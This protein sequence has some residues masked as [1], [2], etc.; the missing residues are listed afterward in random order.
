[1]ILITGAAGF[2]GSV[3]AKSLFQEGQKDLLLVDDFSVESKITNWQSMDTL[4]RIERSLLFDYLDKEKP[5]ISCVIHMGARTD[6]TEFNKAIFDE[7]NLN[8]SKALWQ[9]CA[10]SK[11][12]LIYASSAATYGDGKLGYKDD[13]SIIYQLKPLNPYGESKNNFDQ[14]ALAQEEK[15]PFWAGLKF[16]NVYGPNEYHK[17]R[18]ASVVMHSFN[19]IK[20]HGYANLFKSHRSDFKDGMQS[21]DF[22]YVKDIV[23][24]V[25][26]L[27]RLE[28]P[29]GLYNL[30]T[31]KARPFLALVEAC[32][33]AMGKAKDIRFIP[34]PEDIR[35]KYQYYTQADMN[36]LIAA[37]YADGFY[38]L[39]E[40]VSDYVLNYLSEGKRF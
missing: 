4:K 11:V 12:P 34:T 39:E 13:E 22:V 7:L 37:G 8:Y 5:N 26:F 17:G 35:D 25:K 21:R 36:K 31:G 18:M 38:S 24:V 30:G 2:I 33:E 20:A 10:A 9:W 14:W 23:K 15:P 19:H 16:F 3:I 32:F 40:G 6:T 27:M 29:S 1:M 28:T